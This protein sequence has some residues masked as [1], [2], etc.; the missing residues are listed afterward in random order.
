MILNQLAVGSVIHMH[1]NDSSHITKCYEV[2]RRREVSILTTWDVFPKRCNKSP[3]NITTTYLVLWLKNKVKFSKHIAKSDK[4][5]IIHW[6]NQT[7]TTISRLVGWS[8]ETMVKN[9]STT[10]FQDKDITHYLSSG[11]PKTSSLTPRDPL[12]QSVFLGSLWPLP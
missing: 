3:P 4:A 9:Q 12:A 2:R 1:R 8:A 6:S 7:C 11:T 10:P 5:Q